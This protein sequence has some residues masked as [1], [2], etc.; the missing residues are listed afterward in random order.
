MVLIFREDA[1]V[2]DI[3][4]RESFNIPLDLISRIQFLRQAGHMVCRTEN[5]Q[6]Q[7]KDDPAARHHE[8]KCHKSN[9]EK[10]E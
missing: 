10:G 7:F 9:H 8:K 4:K 3:M 5:N 1:M 2:K 6:N